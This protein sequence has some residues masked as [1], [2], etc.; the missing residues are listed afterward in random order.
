MICPANS[1][2]DAIGKFVTIIL[3]DRMKNGGSWDF[4]P[5]TPLT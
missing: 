3:E 2:E 4:T 5:S 1:V